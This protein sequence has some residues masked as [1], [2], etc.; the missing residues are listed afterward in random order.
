M[1]AID[2]LGMAQMLHTSVLIRSSDPASGE[3]VTV[4]VDGGSAVWDPATTVVFVGRTADQ[5][6]GPSAAICCDHINFFATHSTAEARPARTPRSPAE[7]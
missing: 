4:A 6:A 3:P 2:A 1:C 7:S 5:C